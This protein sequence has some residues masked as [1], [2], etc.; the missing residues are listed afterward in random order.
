LSTATAF[1]SETQY[2]QNDHKINILTLQR[3]NESVARNTPIVNTKT[4][5]D[6]RQYRHFLSQMAMKIMQNDAP[7]PY[8]LLQKR[9][10]QQANYFV[11]EASSPNLI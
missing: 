7:T 2:G 1:W 10:R 5:A 9:C 3:T 8:F 11:S 4:G 6:I